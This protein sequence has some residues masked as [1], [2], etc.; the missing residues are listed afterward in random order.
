MPTRSW[1]FLLF[2]ALVGLPVA[3]AAW[4]GFV[5]LG[6][7]RD[8]LIE[9]ERRDLESRANE[10][11]DLLVARLQELYRAEVAGE[12]M[13]RSPI[14]D[15]FELRPEEED[16]PADV[17]E[18]A[19]IYRGS[20]G[21]HRRPGSALVLH[22]D[23][24]VRLGADPDGVIRGFRLDVERV[25][26]QYL[27]P[28]SPQAV[29]PRADER[30]EFARLVR[31]RERHAGTTD[32]YGLPQMLSRAVVPGDRYATP[33]LLPEGWVL[34]LSMRPS[35]ALGRQLRASGETLGWTLG[36]VGVV[37]A[38][39][40]LFAW[41]ALHAE[42]RL[43]QR[44][45][46]F[47]NAVSHEL[48]TPLTSIRMYADMLKEGWVA[49][50]ETAKDYFGLISA[51]SERLTR[52]VNNVLDFSRVEKGNREFRL[53]VGDPASVVRD[54][55]EVLRPY[56][57]EK[58]F[59]LHLEVPETL[60]ACRFD[61][62]GLAQVMVNLIDNA[63]KYGRDEVCIAGETRD[64]RVVLKVLDRGP[65]V[66]VQEKDSIFE[67]FRRGSGA[68]NTGGSGLG[69]ALARHFADAHAGTIDVTDREGGG[70]VFALTLP[71]AA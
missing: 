3:A 7:E 44:K 32:A 4:L 27:D 60:P 56:L 30:F 9:R 25:A 8:M 41:R 18:L 39:G 49:D 64:G 57:K 1:L 47:V 24:V 63:V 53:Q 11:R 31:E 35:A 67:P 34:E 23:L 20:E 45:A 37:V 26:A 59:A 52:L 71:V 38:L 51:E 40:L 68:A 14:R 70:A 2:A 6:R 16:L 5:G 21:R 19:D 55:A 17:A 50:A 66:P 33:V 36:A 28:V 22:G 58:G 10:V 42:A 61:K 69:L 13:P 46:E 29:V 12:P 48:R 15:R 54:V 43:A 65:G 62:D